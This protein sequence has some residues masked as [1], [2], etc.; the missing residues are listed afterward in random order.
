MMILFSTIE[1]VFEQPTEMYK[2]LFFPLLTIDLLEMGKGPGKVHFI[3]VW[4]CGGA[5]EYMIFDDVSFGFDFIKFGWTGEKYLFDNKLFNP[6]YTETLLKWHAEIEQE[7]AENKADYLTPKKP[8][9]EVE[10]SNLVKREKE[11]AKTS[12][13]YNLYA[14]SLLNYW[15]TKDKFFETGKFIQGYNYTHG[16]NPEVQA[17]QTFISLSK[18]KETKLSKEFIGKV[19]GYNYK[20]NGEDEIGL[21]IDR[22]QNKVFQKFNWT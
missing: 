14:K 16:Y 7:Y 9:K 6:E 8:G 5:N 3:S 10:E 22:K 4:G 20:D 11:R 12:G 2:T 13:D 19:C 15:I 18:T 17:R 21:Y 1:E